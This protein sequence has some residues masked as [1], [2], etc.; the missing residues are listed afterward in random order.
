MRPF[1]GLGREYLTGE[2]DLVV[3]RPRL[4]L[5]SGVRSQESGVRSQESGVRSQES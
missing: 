1:Q 4:T 5:R 3:V 2:E